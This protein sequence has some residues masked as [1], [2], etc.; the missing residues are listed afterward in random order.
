MKKSTAALAAL[1]LLAAGTACA[2][3]VA[4]QGMLGKKAL[5]IVDGSEP[6][7]V[8]PGDSFKGVKVLST[9]GDTAVVEAAGKQIHL[10]VGESPASVGNTGPAP[11]SGT[12]VVLTAGSGGHFLSNGRINGQQVRFMVDT[13]ATMVAM[14]EDDARRLGIRY[15]EQGERGRMSTANGTVPAWRV[16]LASVAIG[17]IEVREVEATVTPAEMPYILLGNSF[18]S[19]FSM[20]RESD[21]MVLE[22]RF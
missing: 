18:L 12:R 22:R 17:D 6:K 15:K 21:T 9:S 2:Q 16:K 13:G 11:G 19:R 5:L 3:S 14:G 8:A 10:R 4:L 20:K 1:A 7:T